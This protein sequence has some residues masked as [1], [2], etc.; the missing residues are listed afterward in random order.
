MQR[1]MTYNDK[2]VMDALEKYCELLQQCVNQ[3]KVDKKVSVTWGT[4][5]YKVVYEGQYQ[6]SVHSFV[7]RK[8]GDLYKAAG[9][10]A[11]AKGVR[12]NIVTDLKSIAERMDPYGGYLYKHNPISGK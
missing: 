2:T 1:V 6:N 10:A 4:K 9:W 7:D 12:G 11:P 8:T 5:F 3:H